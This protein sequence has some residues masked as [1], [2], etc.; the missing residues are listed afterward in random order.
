MKLETNRPV[1]MRVSSYFEHCTTGTKGTIYHFNPLFWYSGKAH[2]Y[3]AQRYAA[4]ETSG[5]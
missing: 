5:F 3:H 1:S 2:D 4:R